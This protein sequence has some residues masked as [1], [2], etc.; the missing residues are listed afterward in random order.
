MARIVGFVGAIACFALAYLTLGP[1]NAYEVNRSVIIGGQ[2]DYSVVPGDFLRK[3]GARFGI[4]SRVIAQG[5]GLAADAKLKKGQVLRLDNR[6][7][8]PFGRSNGL[9]VN[10]PQRMLFYLVNGEVMGAYPI[11]PGK[12]DWQTPLGEFTILS[13]EKDKAWIVPVSIQEEMREEGKPVLTE[14]PPG[15]DN[16]LGRYWIGLSLPAIGIH[17]TIVPTSLYDFRSHGCIRLHPDDVE[18]LYTLVNRGTPGDIIY[19]PLLIGMHEGRVYLE[20]HRDAYGRGKAGLKAAQSLATALG[21]YDRVDWSKAA[22]VLKAREGVA[23]DV[24]VD[25]QITAEVLN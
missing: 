16:P 8:V 24:T 22:M 25:Q 6:H 20:A 13:K 5:N 2:F 15:P 14:V 18:A 17:G 10:I 7:L 23:R 11:A 12:P 1:S 9:I 21:L 4:D 3:I 19:Q